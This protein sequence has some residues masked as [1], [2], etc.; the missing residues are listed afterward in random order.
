ML[1]WHLDVSLPLSLAVWGADRHDSMLV[2][3]I[4]DSLRPGQGCGPRPTPTAPGRIDGNKGYDKLPSPG[5]TCA[6]PHHRP[7]RPA[8]HRLR[9]APGPAA[10][11]R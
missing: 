9:P 6:A 3:P 10:V 1:Q 11:G 4:R 2:E 7:D 8:R 5:P